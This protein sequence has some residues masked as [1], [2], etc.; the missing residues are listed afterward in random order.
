MTGMG[1]FIFNSAIEQTR[2]LAEMLQKFEIAI[3]VM[4]RHETEVYR[5]EN[6]RK[7]VYTMAVT[8]NL[9]SLYNR[10]YFDEMANMELERAKRHEYS[11]SLL[12]IDLDHF[13]KIND[14]YGHDVGDIVLKNF[15]NILKECTRDN[16]MVFRLGGEEFVMMMSYTHMQE[17]FEVA[18]GLKDKVEKSCV[19]IGKESICYQFS[20][21][22]S[23]T[24]EEGY[25]LD[26]L[27]K[28]AD[29]KLY[30]AKLAGRNRIVY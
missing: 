4:A 21:G 7:K 10:Y 16:D 30:K 6:E 11:I 23:D 9:T 3:S 14:T 8:D 19:Y 25:S 2:E 15:A 13:K 1:I 29:I 24:E 5:L 12:Y 28:S 20:G 26:A 17:A 27:L 18:K 22:I